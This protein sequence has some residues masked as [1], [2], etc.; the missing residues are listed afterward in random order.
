MKILQGVNAPLIFLCT[1]V[2]CQYGLSA[3]AQE[4]CF[5]D[6]EIDIESA[7]AESVTLSNDGLMMIIS[8]GTTA[9][10]YQRSSEE[11]EFELT[12]N[13]SVTA[14]APIALD[15]A[16]GN[17]AVGIDS[18]LE[19]FERNG[20]GIYEL[21]ASRI[22]EG[23][24]VPQ[25]LTYGVDGTLYAFNVNGNSGVV[26]AV[27]NFESNCCDLTGTLPTQI[28]WPPVDFKLAPTGSGVAVSA[29]RENDP[30]RVFMME[31]TTDGDVSSW[32]SIEELIA[33]AS[34]DQYTFGVSI[35]GGPGKLLVGSPKDR[36][37]FSYENG[38]EGWALSETFLPE[39]V[40]RSLEGNPDQFA[41]LQSARDLIA[42][43]DTN[44]FSPAIAQSALDSVNSVLAITT[45]D[46]GVFKA[47]VPFEDDPTDQP[48]AVTIVVNS[49]PGFP[50]SAQAETEDYIF[51]QGENAVVSFTNNVD[52]SIYI[53][54]FFVEFDAEKSEWILN[55]TVK[56]P[57]ANSVTEVEF[58]FL[59]PYDPPPS[60]VFQAGFRESTTFWDPAEMTDA[61]NA[62]AELANAGQGQ[63]EA[64]IEIRKNLALEILGDA[65]SVGAGTAD[66]G[67]SVQ[68]SDDGTWA[69]VGG[70]GG[71]ANYVYSFSALAQGGPGDGI[72]GTLPTQINDYDEP[73]LISVANTDNGST[74]I[75]ASS[76][77]GR[78][79]V[80]DNIASCVAVGDTDGDGI[81]DD[82]DLCPTQPAGTYDSNLDGCPDGRDL[83]AEVL[84]EVAAVRFDALD[85][86]AA[87]TGNNGKIRRVKQARAHVAK[88][89][90]KFV[91]GKNMTAL[92]KLS[93]AVSLV[94]RSLE[95]GDASRLEVA[96]YGG[97]IVDVVIAEALAENPIEG[98]LLDGVNE[99]LDQGNAA[100]ADGEPK[101][102]LRKRRRALVRF[103]R[104]MNQ[105]ESE[106]N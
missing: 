75:A 50:G 44:N 93:A 53:S 105:V 47:I 49:Y 40:H 37:V 102:A 17:I 23:T 4:Q 51:S 72:C 92:N 13:L 28:D 89:F 76:T 95:S 65:I 48:Y 73:W 10:I 84:A 38:P 2:F 33:P 58:Q 8:G 71:N 21:T 39:E 42:N 61:T 104:I 57:D 56:G 18:G 59:E 30:S 55:A 1:A 67:S 9:Y 16:S 90:Q 43:I 11:V 15:P 31:H 99:L 79:R 82:L 36:S 68:L 45:T 5:A 22:L 20:E 41:S 7:S 98:G 29:V 12:Q 32:T 86:I 27:G 77:D 70:A 97:I 74:T 87:L 34:A 66:Y 64:W 54:D 81:A 19:R 80:F 62:L 35:A 100:M 46:G 83:I 14:G 6:Q 94:P 91:E 103:V 106:G 78:L 101:T 85:D 96:E 25:Q 60:D 88:A 3:D 69:V 26:A 24:S 63:E 52:D